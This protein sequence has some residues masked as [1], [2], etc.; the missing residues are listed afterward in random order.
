MFTQRQVV[1]DQGWYGWPAPGQRPGK[2]HRLVGGPSLPLRAGSDYR[3]AGSLSEVRVL[4]LFTCQTWA[5]TVGSVSSKLH[6]KTPKASERPGRSLFRRN[7][8]HR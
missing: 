8:C 4:T 1:T 5:L 2:A 7:L 6:V 3:R